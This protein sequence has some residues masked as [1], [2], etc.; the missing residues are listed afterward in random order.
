MAVNFRLIS[1]FLQSAHRERL[2]ALM[3]AF[4]RYKLYCQL[5]T[6]SAGLQAVNQCIGRVI[7]HAKDWAVIILADARWAVSNS[8]AR[9][10]LPG[11]IQSSLVVSHSFGEAYSQTTKFC[12]RMV[13]EA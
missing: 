9:S 1:R 8:H 13:Q 10:Q 12:K 3:K 6:D 7:R 4:I 2:L 11:W 5:S